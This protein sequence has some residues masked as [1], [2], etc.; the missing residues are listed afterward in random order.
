MGGWEAEG[1]LRY[2]IGLSCQQ[3]CY[4]CV[5]YEVQ[6]GKINRVGQEGR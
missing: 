5:R 6:T 1:G 2:P 4:V 3:Q